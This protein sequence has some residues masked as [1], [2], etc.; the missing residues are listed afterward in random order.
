LQ[1]D[2]AGKG[3]LLCDD[4]PRQP[5]LRAS[6]F[7]QPKSFHQISAGPR[8]YSGNDQAV[9]NDAFEFMHVIVSKRLK[10]RRLAVI[11]ATN[12]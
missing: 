4:N 8:S 10:L 3:G 12:V 11:D 6:N 1:R 7:C 2:H 9:P 5:F